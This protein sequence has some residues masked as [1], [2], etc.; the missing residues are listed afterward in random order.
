MGRPPPPTSLI[1]SGIDPSS[2]IY[3][4]VSIAGQ[5]VNLKSGYRFEESVLS[6]GI[7]YIQSIVNTNGSNI[8][9]ITGWVELGLQLVSDTG[10]TCNRYKA[11]ANISNCYTQFDIC[12]ILPVKST[13]NSGMFLNASN[14][15]KT[16]SSQAD[17]TFLALKLCDLPKE[18]YI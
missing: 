15:T 4:K 18:D 6:P 17:Y 9:S 3:K 2:Y 14:V 8:G 16:F 12:S 5:P 7:Y 13:V 11:T 10:Y 1:G